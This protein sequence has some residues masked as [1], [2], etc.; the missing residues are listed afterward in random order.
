M[1]FIK[2]PLAQIHLTDMI[3][4]VL[5]TAVLA[6]VS[7]HNLLRPRTHGFYRFLAWECMLVLFLHNRAFW[8]VDRFAWNQ[9]LSWSFLLLSIALVI[10]GAA[11]VRFYGQASNQRND[12]GLMPFEKTTQLVERGIYAH[13]RH[14]LYASL[15]CLAWGV[16]FKQPL[17]WPGMVLVLG[18]TVTLTRAASIEEQENLAYFGAAYAAYMLRSKRFLPCVW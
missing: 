2:I 6:W 18:A 14:P 17:W 12:D 5:G 15:L 11:M 10:S 3:F 1:Q 9:L 16:F 13:I 4:F 7:Q 8:F